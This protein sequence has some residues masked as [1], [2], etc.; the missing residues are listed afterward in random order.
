MGSTLVTGDF[1]E[2]GIDDLIVAPPMKVLEKSNN[3]EVSPFCTDL[4]M[5]FHLK[6]TRIHQGSLAFRIV[7]KPLTDGGQFNNW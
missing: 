5:V 2:D 1:S 3:Q 7:M 4:E 6:I